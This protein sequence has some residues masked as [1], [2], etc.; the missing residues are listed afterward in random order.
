MFSNIRLFHPSV[1]FLLLVQNNLV[2][3]TNEQVMLRIFNQIY[4]SCASKGVSW[5]NSGM[6]CLPGMSHWQALGQKQN[7]LGRL[8]MSSG[9]GIPQDEMEI[10]AGERNVYIRWH[11]KQ[12]SQY[13]GFEIIL[14][15]VLISFTQEQ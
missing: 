1:C 8:Y 2:M 3:V 6:R 12:K 11:D 9:F 14:Q 10:G 15:L 5:D 4:Y 7:M 13:L